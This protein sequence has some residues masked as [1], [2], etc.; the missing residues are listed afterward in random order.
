MLV[1]LKEQ[2]KIINTDFIVRIDEISKAINDLMDDLV[3]LKMD[4]EVKP[5][6]VTENKCCSITMSSGEKIDIETDIFSMWEYISVK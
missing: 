2:N 5:S 1:W 3:N 6:D 4:E